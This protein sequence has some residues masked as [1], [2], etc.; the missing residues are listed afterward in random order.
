[1][2]LADLHQ[3]ASQ[4]TP[5]VFPESL[6]TDTTLPLQFSSL[7]APLHTA[8]APLGTPQAPHPP[9][10]H[11]HL[12]QQKQQQQQQH[13][14]W[15]RACQTAGRVQPLLAVGPTEGVSPVHRP[16]PAWLALG[17]RALVPGA[18]A[19]LPAVQGGPGQ[20]DAC[21]WGANRG[22]AP[23]LVWRGRAGRQPWKRC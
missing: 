1:V 10:Q 19:V 12:Q 5:V 11:Q 20:L 13:S 23:V 4:G 3:T 14:V 17:F 15:G 18:Q 21:T 22:G 2:L 16:D 9:A 8:Q 6:N 7:K